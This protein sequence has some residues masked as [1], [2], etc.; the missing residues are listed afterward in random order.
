METIKQQSIL[1][2]HQNGLASRAIAAKLG[3]SKTSVNNFLKK[4]REDKPLIPM[5]KHRDIWRIETNAN[6]R[7]GCTHVV[8]PD[9]QVRPGVNITYLE[10]IGKYIVDKQPE[11]I[12]HLGDHADMPSLSSYDRGQRSAEG[13][14]V[15]KDIDSAVEGM[16]ALLE[17]LYKLQQK[18]SNIYKPRLVITLGNHEQRILRHTQMYPNLHEFLSYNNLCYTAM[19][20]DQFDFLK[21]VVIHGVTYC[22]YMANPMTGKPYGGSAM[23]ILKNVGESFTVGHKQTLDIATRA[24][25][26]SG[27]QQWGI[28]A[29]ACYLHDED[30]KGPQGN[31][32]WRGIIVKH[33]V[34]NGSYNPMFVSLDY[35]KDRYK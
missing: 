24:L 4:Q 13:K 30:Y 35:L 3:I 32:H 11:V 20:W 9:T 2:H 10:W 21:P 28:V 15:G 12:V 1:K 23:A 31:H 18:K 26:A 16:K 7:P 6:P 5:T 25:P 8:I 14:R 27:K 17:P 19:G 34:A 33:E 29:G 22:H